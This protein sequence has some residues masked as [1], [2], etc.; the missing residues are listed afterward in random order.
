MSRAQSALIDFVSRPA[1]IS[2]NADCDFH[3]TIGDFNDVDFPPPKTVVSKVWQRC[4]Q[5]LN[6][7][8]SER[9]D[10]HIDK[11]MQYSKGIH[12]FKYITSTQR[13][14]LCKNMTCTTLV[15]NQMVSHGS[16]LQVVASLHLS[17]VAVFLL[18][19]CCRRFF[20]MACSFQARWPLGGDGGDS[21]TLA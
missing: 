4:Q 2:R 10:A 14:D 7:P 5:S 20:N 16:D 13:C 19:S 15:R 8:P 11:I 1:Q 3:F 21:H 17:S 18:A 9:T 12:F 6:V